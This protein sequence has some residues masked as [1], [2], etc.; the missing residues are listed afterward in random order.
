[1]AFSASLTEIPAEASCPR[2]LDYLREPVTLE[3]G[4]N[5]CDSCIHQCWVDL[6]DVFPCPVCLRH[7]PDRNFKRNKQLCHITEV[8]KQLPT[9]RSKRKWQAEEPLC[10]K[11]NEA[12]D[13]FCEE[14]QELLCPQCRVSTHNQGHH[15]IPTDRAA[16]SQR[17]KLKGFIE[18]LKTK[19]SDAKKECENQIAQ[20]VGGR[21]KIA[22]WKGELQ[23][24]LEQFKLSLRDEQFS[25]HAS[26]LNREREM[27]EKIAQNKSQILSSMDTVKN[28]LRDI[29]EK[30]LQADQDFLA[31]AENLQHRY[32]NPLFPTVSSY[33]FKNESYTL[34]PN[35]VVL[36]KMMSKFQDPKTAHPSL[37]VS[38]DR[39]RV[40]LITSLP[41]LLDHPHVENTPFLGV[42]CCEA[43][44]GGR[45]FWQVE[46][47]GIGKC[48]LGVCEKS[49]CNHIL[50]LPYSVSEIWQ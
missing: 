11:H 20:S 13:L 46:V 43:F 10:E 2:C 8:L 47:K 44:D 29:T 23:A 16:E 19:M 28:L 24:E 21:W 15:L 49:F 37:T 5:F 32:K 33:E 7:C 27:E 1:M 48:S 18:L 40:N 12:V 14:D 45:H 35:Y 39:K 31:T 22:S 41:L 3:W 50:T 17:K 42:L 25:I 36:H 30:C 34:P 26:L 6:Q 4:H 9:G 38:K